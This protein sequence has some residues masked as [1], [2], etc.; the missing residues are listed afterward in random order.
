[1][2]TYGDRI[3]KHQIIA[4]A[5][6][7]AALTANSVSALTHKSGVIQ[8]VDLTSST[9]VVTGSRGQKEAYRLTPDTRILVDGKQHGL[10]ALAPQ[11]EVTVAIPSSAPAFVRAKI[12]EVDVATGLALVRLWDS[13]DTITVRINEATKV[14][15]R[16]SSATELSEGQTIKMRYAA[17]I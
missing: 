16:I 4:T 15:G 14:G 12:I 11:Q 1:M 6:L 7:L 13:K 9:L 2:V 17:S 8:S 3:M 10:S 5:A